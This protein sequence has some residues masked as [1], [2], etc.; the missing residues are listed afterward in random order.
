MRTSFAGKWNSGHAG[1][2]ARF[3]SYR[4]DCDYVD[5]EVLERNV[6]EH[7]HSDLQTELA[8]YFRARRKQ[9]R[10]HAV[11]EQRVQVKPSRFRI[12]DVCIVKAPGPHPA[13][14]REPPFICIEVL[15]KDDSLIRTHGRIDDYLNFASLYSASGGSEVTG[16]VLRTESPSIE[17]PLLEIFAGPDELPDA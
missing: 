14:F 15:S 11:V 4:P 2:D 17:I 9:W 5:G 12:P 13:I 7:G 8:Y 1:T 6:G 3:G 10:L 16:G